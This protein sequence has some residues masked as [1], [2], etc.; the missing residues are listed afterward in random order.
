MAVDMGVLL[1]SPLRILGLLLL[2]VVIKAAVMWGVAR[3]F[4]IRHQTSTRMALLLAQ[5]GEF[6][7]VLFGAALHAQLFDSDI[8]QEA[9]LV[10]ALSMAVTPLLALRLPQKGEAA[11]LEEDESLG[12]KAETYEEHPD[13]IIAGF[14]R[15]GQRIAT[16]LTDAGVSYVAIEQRPKLVSDGRAKGY[17]VYY[18]NAGEPEVLESAGVGR[19]KLMVV[20]VDNAD[21]VE[22]LVGDIHRLYPAL[23]IFARGHSRSRCEHLLNIGAAGVSSE[24]LEASLQLSRFALKATGVDDEHVEHLLEN[25]REQYYQYL[26]RRERREQDENGD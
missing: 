23:P 24:N 26:T 1:N 2:L 20:A 18:G 10:V 17:A 8:Y 11:A 3:S 15:M 16:L 12:L 6:G 22:R 9:I 4:G 5:S 7:F 13:V 14:G 19:A 21:V 25:Y